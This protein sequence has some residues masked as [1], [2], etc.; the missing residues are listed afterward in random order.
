MV[1]D[2]LMRC[3]LGPRKGALMQ[4]MWVYE[5]RFPLVLQQLRSLDLITTCS[6]I[7]PNNALA[8]S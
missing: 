3:V 6:R 2:C 4:L 5:G 8:C 1:L 7:V